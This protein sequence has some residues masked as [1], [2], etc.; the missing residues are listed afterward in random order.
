M[1]SLK[2]W[3]E[4]IQHL[5]RY[6][7]KLSSMKSPDLNSQNITFVFNKNGNNWL[8]EPIEPISDYYGF[9]HE[10]DDAQIASM[11]I[12]SMKMLAHYEAY[13]GRYSLWYR[14][15][16]FQDT[17]QSREKFR[18]LIK[19][20]K[21]F[22][23]VLGNNV[24][25]EHIVLVSRNENYKTIF[26]SIFPQK[27]LSIDVNRKVLPKSIAAN[28]KDRHNSLPVRSSSTVQ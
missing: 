13:R 12:N 3:T 11:Y 20:R 25:G 2:T 24:Y 9:L 21:V 8:L 18:S 22:R 5:G 7:I 23:R 17:K 26:Y 10:R 14:N 28:L 15:F 19:F 16:F 4:I 27:S 6:G 1:K